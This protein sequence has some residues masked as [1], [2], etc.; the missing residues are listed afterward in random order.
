M[1][2]ITGTQTIP[3]EWN[4][5][6]AGTLTLKLPDGTVRKRYP[7]HVKLKQEGGY[8]VSAKQKVQRGRFKDGR[9]QFKNTG[10]AERARWYDAQPIWN[11]V[12]WYYNYFMMSAISGVLGVIPQGAQVIKSI[13]NFIVTC[14]NSQNIVTI[15][16]AVDTN[17]VIVFIFGAGYDVNWALSGTV[18]EF[19]AWKRTPAWWGLNS[20]RMTMIMENDIDRDA[21]M[22]VQIIEYI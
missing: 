14:G 4:D 18:F 2:K 1:V 15:P 9:D 17:K 3:A 11:S 16:T 12:L 6:Y 7:F 19:F 5:E 21:V 22:T 20:S 10:S 8:K 13:Q